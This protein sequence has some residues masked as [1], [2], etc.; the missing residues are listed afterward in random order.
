M[1]YTLENG[2]PVEIRKVIFEDLTITNPTD[3]FIDENGLGY[4][5]Q[6]SEAPEYDPANEKISF[7]WKIQDGTIKQ[8]WVVEE[9][10]QE[11]KRSQHNA[12]IDAEIA[13][14]N[15]GYESYKTTPLEYSFKN[16]SMWLKPIWLTEYYG[17][18]QQVGIITS[19]ATF[20]M[21]ITDATGVNFEMTFEEFSTMYLWLVQKAQTETKRVNDALAELEAQ[22][23][24]VNA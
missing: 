11:E 21:I 4:P 17:T 24:V 23:E 12:E 20:P 22:K 14:V 3:T 19:G 6:E 5:K 10:S 7:T 1:R 16:Q 2:F 9:L 15:A 8:I 18:L 13:A